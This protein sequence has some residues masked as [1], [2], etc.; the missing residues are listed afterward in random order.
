[1]LKIPLVDYNEIRSCGIK[2]NSELAKLLKITSLIVWDE[3]VM[4][5]KYTLIALDITLRDVL[6]NDK[7]MGGIVFVCAGDF[8][9][10]LPVIRGG[11]KNEE[12][13][14][15]IKS[16]YLWEGLTKLELTENVRLKTNYVRNKSFVKNLLKLG[17]GESGPVYFLENFGISV[18]TREELVNKV[19]D[20]IENNHLNASYFEKRAIISP[21]NDDVD[22]IN[23]MIYEKSEE[24]VVYNS[25]D[26]A[27]ENYTDIQ[28]SVFNALTS[29]SLPLHQ[30]KVKIGSVLMII[31]N[32]CP[33]KLC[34]GSRIIVTN[35]K[36]NVIVGKILG[37]SYGGEQV[38]IPKITLEAQ[39]T[40]VPFKRKQF[41]VK[42]S[43]AMTINKSQG[44]TFERCGLLLDYVQC[45]AHGQLY[46]ACSR[47]TN[48]NSLIVYTGWEKVNDEYQLRPAIN[49]V[50][51]ELFSGEFDSVDENL[52]QVTSESEASLFA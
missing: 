17:T 37:G 8:R 30:L 38:F 11:G 25:V 34:N 46:V 23:S 12:L 35:L 4:A 28:T 5:N 22:S 9:Q 52:P 41:L 7:F 31:R 21:T 1:M 26:T 13:E 40:P 10:I 36:K 33:P 16:S 51:K 29:P 20:D 6:E 27:T 2:K 3:V 14:H 19:Y 42:L 32:I 39:D 24:E 44:Q 45:F 49:R 15:C 47:V 48:W 18:K 50:Y 43:Y